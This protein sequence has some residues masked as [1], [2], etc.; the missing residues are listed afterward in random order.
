MKV[1]PNFTTVVTGNLKYGHAEWNSNRKRTYKDNC[2]V[3]ERPKHYWLL[4]VLPKE[5]MQQR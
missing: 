1:H 3:K 2:V 5:V 4:I